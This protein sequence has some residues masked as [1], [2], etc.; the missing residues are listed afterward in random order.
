MMRLITVLIANLKKD[1]NRTSWKVR[2]VFSHRSLVAMIPNLKMSHADQTPVPPITACLSGQCVTGDDQPCVDDPGDGLSDAA[3][4]SRL[5]ADGDN[6][7][8][9]GKRC[10]L[11]R[12][13]QENR[14]EQALAA[15]RDL[16]GTHATV[17]CG[18]QR[19]RIPARG[20]ACGDLLVV[21]E[22]DRVAADGLCCLGATC[23][24]TSHYLLESPSRCEQIPVK[25]VPDQTE[26]PEG[27]DLPF[28]FPGTLI[29]QDRGFARGPTAK[30]G[31]ISAALTTVAQEATRTQEETTRIV[32]RLA[33]LALSRSPSTFANSKRRPSGVTRPKNAQRGQSRPIHADPSSSATLL[34]DWRWAWS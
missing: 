10:S 5:E 24:P 33:W 18:A 3:A 7:L 20:V 21:D 8:A 30:I 15:L 25:R 26:K 13:A 14:T 2:I 34:K 1:A 4:A 16:S 6:D 31:H 22:G 11:V 23:P 29:I 19:Q 28:L 12:I 32:M 27:D 17:I 9:S